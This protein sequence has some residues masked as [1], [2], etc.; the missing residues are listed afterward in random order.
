M[1]SYLSALHSYSVVN[2][3]QLHN[4]YKRHQK[5]MFLIDDL[6]SLKMEWPM[7]SF[8][9]YFEQFQN[10]CT[11]ILFLSFMKTRNVEWNDI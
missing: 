2:H 8:Q 10:I 1:N 4:K 7:Q 11:G 5:E 6:M 9:G 3:I